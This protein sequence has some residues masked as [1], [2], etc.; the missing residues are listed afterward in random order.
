MKSFKSSHPA[1]AQTAKGT[2]SHP[3]TSPSDPHCFIWSSSEPS[4]LHMVLIWNPT[5][6]YGRH[7][8]PHFS[9]WSS[10]EP[11]LLHMVVIWTPTSP[12]GPHLNPHFSIWSSS[13]P[14]LLHMVLIWTPT[15]PYGPHLN[16]HFSIWSSSETPL[17]HM[18]LIWFP[19][20]KQPSQKK[21]ARNCLNRSN[22]FK[23]IEALH[24]AKY[25]DGTN[26]KITSN[27]LYYHSYKFFEPVNDPSCGKIDVETMMMMT[28]MITTFRSR[29][30]N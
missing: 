12:Y 21:L 24:P 27:I 14:S 6:P 5:S 13:E 2:R 19:L 1:S 7:L 9:I 20:P 25:T 8:N 15:S 29:C 11:P 16:P 4:L 22:S 26:S 30:N 3:P 10:S 18:V 28:M 23:T 17:L